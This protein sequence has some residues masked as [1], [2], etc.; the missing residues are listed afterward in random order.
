MTQLSRRDFLKV[1]AASTAT[2]I[3]AGCGEDTERYV[4]LEPYVRAP[5]QQPAG[6]ATWYATTC[7]QCPAGCGVLVRIMNG[8]AKK[9]EG[10]PEHPVNRGKLCAR[11]QAGLQLLYNPDRL[12]GAVMQEERGSAEFDA[13]AWNQAI[14]TLYEKINAAGD[15]VGVWLGSSTSAHLVD[16]FTRFINAIGAPAPVIY[17]LYS[18]FNGFDALSATTEEL[19]GRASLP[20]YSLHDAD[21]VFSFGADFLGTWLNSTGYGYEYGEFRSQPYGKRGLFVQF[22]P[23]MSNSGAKADRW[24]PLQPGAEVLVAQAIARLMADENLGSTERV[25]RAARYIGD[26]S[27]DLEAAAAACLMSVEELTN[28]TRAFATAEKPV[29]LAGATVSGRPDARAAAQAVQMLNIIV[30]TPGLYT[31]PTFPSESIVTPQAST[32]ADVQSMIER[33][34]AGEIDVLLVHGADPAYELPEHL[35]FTDAL[36]NVADVISFS[37]LVDDTALHAD[38]ILPDRVYLEGWGYAIPT[39]VPNGLPVI[40]SQQPVVTPFYDVRATGDILLTVA[41]GIPAA[42]SALPWADEVAFLKETIA[43]L[44][45]GAHSGDD[46]EVIW[47]RFQ[48]F[49]GWWP[50]EASA[51]AE[52]PDVVPASGAATVPEASEGEYPYHLHLFMSPLLGDGRGASQPWLQGSPDPMTTISWQTWVEINPET[53]AE[54]DVENGDIVELAS[55][56]GTIEAQVYVYPAIRPDTVAVVLGQGHA[57][58][59]RY[60]QDR[61][62]NPV[63]LVGLPENSGDNLAWAATRVKVT[64][65]DDS[66]PLARFESSIEPGENIHIPF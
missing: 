12:Q 56:N 63:R 20:S 33:M 50:A 55:P 27:V 26:T 24:V 10:N 25:E 18:G 53:A 28:L 64:R 6:V 65:T 45:G 32:L 15:R 3:L 37:P 22:E 61:G 29:A 1:S 58:L 51:A 34:N 19:F 7:R 43:S 62:S 59:G 13:L 11:G 14:N 35:G 57:A 48:Q 4:E 31:T 60:A 23:R 5:E 39:P 52:A 46:P 16:L 49:G 2:V 40:S 21:V 66:H 17:D 9:I 38:M 54:L 44:P 47:A 30:A 36:Q 42:A 8:R 41:R